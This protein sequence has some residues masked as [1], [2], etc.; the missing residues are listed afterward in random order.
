MNYT[1]FV[2]KF[3]SSAGSSI[4]ESGG[5]LVGLEV[6]VDLQRSFLSLLS[7]FNHGEVSL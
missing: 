4:I 7:L 1:I 5:G 2:T 3:F 6:E